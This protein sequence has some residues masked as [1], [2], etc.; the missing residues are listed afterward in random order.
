MVADDGS[1]VWELVGSFLFHELSE[2]TRKNN[3]GLT[4]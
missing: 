3:T 1:E 4:H 2:N